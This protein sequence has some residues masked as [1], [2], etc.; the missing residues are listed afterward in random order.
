MSK[1]YP[2]QDPTCN[3]IYLTYSMETNEPRVTCAALSGDEFDICMEKRI[4]I[5]FVKFTILHESWVLDNHD[6]DYDYEGCTWEIAPELRAQMPI[7]IE[8]GGLTSFFSTRITKSSS[9]DVIFVLILLISAAALIS[10][11]LLIY[12]VSSSLR[13]CSMELGNKES[14]SIIQTYFSNYQ[15]QLC[16]VQIRTVEQSF[17]I[18]VEQYN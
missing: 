7:S 1:P 5:N 12:R 10:C 16:I 15:K 11:G 2:A 13:L 6:W 9:E 18:H 17:L 14:V 3:N 8:V 4:T